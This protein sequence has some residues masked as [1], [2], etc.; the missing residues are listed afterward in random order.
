MRYASGQKEAYPGVPGA[1]LP[2]SS[3][4]G[5]GGFRGGSFVTTFGGTTPAFKVPTTGTSTKRLVR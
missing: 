2:G 3:S 4:S 1:S 5:Y